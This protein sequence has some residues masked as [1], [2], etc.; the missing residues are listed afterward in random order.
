[1]ANFVISHN[2]DQFI[3]SLGRTNTELQKAAQ[4]GATQLGK[5]AAKLYASTVRNWENQPEFTVEVNAS[6]SRIEVLAGTDDKIYGYVD[7]GTRVRRAVM[8]PD[9]V[10]KTQPGSLKSGRGRGRVVFISKKISRPGI[11]ARNFSKGIKETLDKKAEQVFNR[12]I[13]KAIR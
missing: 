10:S 1:M 5:E 12:E 11:Q 2:I 9:W 13:K 3:K 8:S 6:A 7:E 4:A